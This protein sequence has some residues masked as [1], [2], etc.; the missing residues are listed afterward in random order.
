MA[1]AERER[2]GNVND[3]SAGDEEEL[4]K[5]GAAFF[6]REDSEAGF[7]SSSD[8]TVAVPDEPGVR[9]MRG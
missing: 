1:K 4:D 7:A 8:G 6:P 9:V 5:T 3:T 2:Q